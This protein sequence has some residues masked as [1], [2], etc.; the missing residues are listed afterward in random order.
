M[1][2]ALHAAVMYGHE[3]IVKLLVEAD[4]TDIHTQNNQG[5]TPIS[6]AVEKGLNDI[7]EIISTT[8][9]APF[10][11]G[12][13]GSTAAHANNLDQ[14][15]SAGGTHYRIRDRDALF[16]SAIAGDADAIARLEMNTDILSKYSETILHIESESGNTKHVQFILREFGY[17]NLLFKLNRFKQ[18]ALQLAVCKGHTEVAEMIIEA[19]RRQFQETSFQAFLRH[20]DKNNDTALHA[21]VMEGNVAIVKLLVKDDPDNTHLQNYDEGKTPM[22]IAVEK[23][24]NAI[25]E[26]ISSICTA[27]SID[28]PHGSTALH[29]AVKNGNDSI[30]VVK[31]LIDVARRLPTPV[32]DSTDDD[33][34]EDDSSDDNRDSNPVTS[35][36]EYYS[37]SDDD[38]SDEHPVISSS[39]DSSSD[40]YSTNDPVSYF[41]R[42][43]DE[44]GN[45]ALHITVMQGNLDTAKLLV[46]A[47]PSDGGIQNKKGETPFYIAAER[48]YADILK[49]ICTTCTAAPFSLVGPG[50][51]ATALHSVIKNLHE[52]SNMSYTFLHRQ[53][54]QI[55]KLICKANKGDFITTV[56]CSTSV[57]AA[58]N[59]VKD[60][61][62]MIIDQIKEHNISAGLDEIFYETDEDGCTIL[63]LAVELNKVAVV[64][65]ILDLQSP[66]SKRNDGAFISLMPL[67][68]KAQEKDYNSIAELLT[69]RYNDGSKLAKDFKDQVSLISAIRSGKSAT[70]Q[71]YQF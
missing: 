66:L 9:N 44:D 33:E 25:V 35:F 6:I 45:T 22:Y 63:E 21:A 19:A 5:K 29:A 64:E 52:G 42:R 55:A 70:P 27:P 71:S 15:K 50:G 43:V 24:Y 54:R 11:D 31:V 32:D 17:K 1:D 20:G 46:E 10:P 4:P 47:D 16:E 41:L 8:C 68:Y 39:Q 59:E 30:E 48:G 62:E 12:P 69:E 58:N 23:G 26:L 36:E 67:I 7:V 28:G 60:V 57:L 38:S 34:D 51:G 61:I 14:V 53:R 49:M 40:T 2:T 13:D 3:A 37:S 56:S 65:L 18:T